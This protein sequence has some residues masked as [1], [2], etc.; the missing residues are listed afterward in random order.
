MGVVPRLAKRGMSNLRQAAQAALEAL[1]SLQG[2][3]TDHDD[4]TVE[5]ITVWCPEVVEALRAA[6]AEP[7][8]DCERRPF[9]DLRNAKW[10]DPECYEEGACQSLKFKQAQQPQPKPVAWWL[11]GTG[12]V[13]IAAEFTPDYEHLGD[14]VPLV[15][16]AAPQAQQPLTDDPT[17]KHAIKVPG[18]GWV[19]TKAVRAIEAAHGIK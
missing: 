15:R 16:G 17:N 8:P 11:Y 4:G 5:A 10:L 1:E 18:Y 3:C 19:D 12:D 7:Q 6:L 14:W 13:Y 2:G 9:G